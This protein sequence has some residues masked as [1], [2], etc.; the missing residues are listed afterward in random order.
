MDWGYTDSSQWGYT[1]SSQNDALD[2]IAKVFD[3]K[4]VLVKNSEDCV[5]LVTKFIQDYM[6]IGMETVVRDRV[7]NFLLNKTKHAMT[8]NQLEDIWE[9]EV[10]NGQGTMTLTTC[11]IA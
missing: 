6:N 9:T 5:P 4:V 7:R 11:V 8:E 1:D 2:S 10:N 3:S